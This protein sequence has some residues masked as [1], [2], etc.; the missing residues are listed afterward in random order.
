[1]KLKRVMAFVLSLA[2]VV[3]SSS[4]GALSVYAAEDELLIVEDSSSD[5]LLD[6]ST[7]IEDK[8]DEPLEDNSNVLQDN[9]PSELEDNSNVLY[10]DSSKDDTLQVE[11]DSIVS[12]N[13]AVK[14]EQASG[15]TRE[16]KLKAEVDPLQIVKVGDFFYA[17]DTQFAAVAS[18]EPEDAT[19]TE[20]VIPGE[21]DLQGTTYE[22]PLLEDDLKRVVIGIGASAFEEGEEHQLRSVKMADT[23]KIIAPEAFADCTLLTS[24]ELP[25]VMK[26]TATDV[27]GVGCIDDYAFKGCT[28]LA[29]VKL[30][31]ELD[32]VGAGIFAGCESLTSIEIPA[33]WEATVVHEKDKDKPYSIAEN[34]D[35]KEGPFSNCDALVNIKFASNTKKIADC[36]LA[37]CDSIAS[38]TIPD[39]VNTIGKK[40]FYSCDKLEKFEIGN[41]SA[42]KVVDDWAFQKCVSLKR[43]DF[44]KYTATLGTGAFLDC[45]ALTATT[46]PFSINKIGDRAYLKC[47]ELESVVFGEGVEQNVTGG[48]IG[49]YAFGDNTYNPNSGYKYPLSKITHVTIPN[50]MT[51]IDNSAFEGCTG[52]VS[53]EVDDMCTF[54]GMMI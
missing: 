50:S 22:S 14:D 15:R 36:L 13:E 6:E 31:D 46:V 32:A 20:A 42:L 9:E 11:E 53:V 18:W 12:E 34:T 35:I 39:G 3:T 44:P 52:L 48:T 17:V 33:G 23:V 27:F 49:K 1:M 25:R 43:A 26:N 10:D 2:L 28:S 41:A 21:I 47:V 29:E 40:T 45:S 19:A 7:T 16:G 24:I 4:F 30:P 37:N 5:V 8:S 51:T 54:A 38:V